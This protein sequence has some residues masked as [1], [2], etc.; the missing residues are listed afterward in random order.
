MSTVDARSERAPEMLI[1]RISVLVEAAHDALIELTLDADI[2]ADLSCTLAALD[3][4]DALDQ[5]HQETPAPD[6]LSAAPLPCAPRD[7]ADP[8][9]A[10][11]ACLQD[12]LRLLADGVAVVDDLSDAELLALARVAHGLSHVF[13]RLKLPRP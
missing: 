8:F 6:R 1:R 4:R 10:V 2:D 7:R 12:A 3:L 9:H 5:L 11:G 13:E